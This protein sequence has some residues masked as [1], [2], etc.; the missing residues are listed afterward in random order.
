MSYGPE[1]LPKYDEA[2]KWAPKDLARVHEARVGVCS[3]I[4]T[5]EMPAVSRVSSGEK[6]TRWQKI[7]DGTMDKE[8]ASRLESIKDGRRSSMVESDRRSS[9]VEDPIEEARTRERAQR[10]AEHNAATKDKAFE[11][12]SSKVSFSVSEVSEVGI[13]E[14]D[15]TPAAEEEEEEDEEEEEAAAAAAAVAEPEA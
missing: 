13:E 4:P 12:R 14:K 5:C 6:Q 1:F 15:D 9:K 7:E 3:Q 11:E 2:F 8:R 10:A